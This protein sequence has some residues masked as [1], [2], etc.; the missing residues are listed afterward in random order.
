M[1]EI[2]PFRGILYRP[3]PGGDVSP[4]LAPPYD[5]I[6]PAERD[7]LAARDPHNCV[8]LILPKDEAGGESDGRYEVA[9][10]TLRQWLAEGVMARDTRPAIYRYHQVFTPPGG[11]GLVTRRGFIARIRL[12]R[13]EERIILPHERTLAGP[14]ADRLKLKRATRTHLS[15]VFGLFRD[16]DLLAEAAFA[17]LEATLPHLHGKTPDGV[18]HRLWCLTDRPAQEAVA[19]ALRD[20]RIYIAD[21][22]H[23]YETMLALRDELRHKPGYLGVQSSIEY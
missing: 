16:P 12:H 22:H 5:V 11:T 8:R 14:K 1:A 17:P 18:E 4:V 20:K 7:E 3:A 10:R 2:A 19:A 13:F 15:Q 21:G 23:R 6:S 9:A